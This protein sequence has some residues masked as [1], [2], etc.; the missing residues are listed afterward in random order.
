[1][2]RFPPAKRAHICIHTGD[3]RYASSHHQGR[4]CVSVYACYDL[5]SHETYFVKLGKN[6]K[7]AIAIRSDGPQE[8]FIS[9]SDAGCHFDRW[10]EVG[11]RR[12]WNR[13]TPTCP[14][15]KAEL[16]QEYPEAFL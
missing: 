5:L 10:S 13:A 7:M 1:M 3:V 11:T 16:R 12:L 6:T 4:T 8:L 15:A 14:K 2:P 9:I